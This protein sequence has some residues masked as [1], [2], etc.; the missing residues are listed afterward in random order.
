MENI[1]NTNIMC[2]CQKECKQYG[3]SEHCGTPWKCEFCK[4]LKGEIP[5]PG[6]DCLRCKEVTEI[7]SM[8]EEN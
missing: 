1:K 4:Y 3:V 5:P 2:T 7:F 8:M 6:I